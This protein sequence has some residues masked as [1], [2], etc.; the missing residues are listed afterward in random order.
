[1]L[2]HDTHVHSKYS[3]D[4]CMDIDEICELAIERNI[5]SIAI[6]DHYDIDGIVY[7]YYPSYD[8]DSAYNDVM[9]AK[10]KYRGKL[11]ITY[12]IELGQAHIMLKEAAGFLNR[13]KFE[14]VIGSAHNLRDVPDFFFM[15]YDIMSIELCERLWQRYLDEVYEMLTFDGIH[16]VAHLTYPIR[17]MVQYNKQIEYKKFYD[18]IMKIYKKMI[19]KGVC[20]EINTSGLRQQMKATMPDFELVKLYHDCGGELITVGS[21]AHRAEHLGMN[22][23]DAYDMAKNIGY[24]YITVYID[25][26]P[27]MIKL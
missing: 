23:I 18:S 17:Y 1:M 4:G 11:R 22:I 19:T 25:G 7:G 9:T 27:E 15:K 6:T 5:E 8:A 2:I 13:Y 14:F 20:L 16:T 10:D 21:D 12:G 24:K 3:F 26:K